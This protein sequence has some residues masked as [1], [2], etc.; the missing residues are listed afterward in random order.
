MDITP[1][2]TGNAI[3]DTP[4]YALYQ[5]NQLADRT[6]PDSPDLSS[7]IASILGN[8][9]PGYD[10]AQAKLAG[11]INAPIQ[12]QKWWKDALAKG[13]AI[14]SNVY[15]GGWGD[16]NKQIPVEGYGR[17]K[18]DQ[19]VNKALGQFEPLRALENQ[20][21]GD[22]GRQ[23]GILNTVEDNRRA[24][25]QAHDLAQ[26][27]KDTIT[28]RA[29]NRRSRD[30]NTKMRTVASM[31]SKIP[32][33]DPSDP[34]FGEITKALGDI[35]L[36]LAPKDVK[37]NIRLVQDAETGAWTLALTDPY[38]GQQEVRPVVDKQGKQ[39]TTA[40]TAKVAADAA[41]GRQTSQQEF[42]LKKQQI[43]NQLQKE[44]E[45]FKAEQKEAAETNDMP[46][47]LELQKSIE[48]RQKNILQFKSDLEKAML[49]NP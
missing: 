32:N 13:G 28:E 3:P 39:L 15:Q 46:R 11:A 18:H 22:I 1:V 40:S 34:R 10:D 12:K 14:L 25:Q 19:G 43:A 17:L 29:E 9:T 4:E 5:Q 24:A 35:G 38:S 31:L 27:R 33:Y 21:V 2:P 45:T 36:P 6:V 41:A 16:P 44:M 47:K 26:F 20:R 8:R 30:N 37:K 42:E 49:E 7:S 23:V 48:Q